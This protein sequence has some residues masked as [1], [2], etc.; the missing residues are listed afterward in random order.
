MVFDDGYDHSR[1]ELSLEIVNLILTVDMEGGGQVVL[2]R[3]KVLH[4]ASLE[5]FVVPHLAGEYLKALNLV[6]ILIRSE[7]LIVCMQMRF[8]SAHVHDFYVVNLSDSGRAGSVHFFQLFG[9]EAVVEIC[10]TYESGEFGF[11]VLFQDL[12]HFFFKIDLIWCVL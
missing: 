12:E 6:Q 9:Q 1:E 5:G 3:L 7:C 4:F 11:C 2:Q 8:H 10:L